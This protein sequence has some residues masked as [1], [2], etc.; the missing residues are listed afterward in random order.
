MA[1]LVLLVCRA[2][3]ALQGIRSEEKVNGTHNDSDIRSD[4]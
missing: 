3:S 4:N 2:E 1:S